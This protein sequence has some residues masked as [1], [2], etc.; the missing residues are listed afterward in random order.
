MSVSVIESDWF[1]AV[2]EAD[3]ERKPRHAAS[4]TAKR[5]GAVG[6]HRAVPQRRRDRATERS[7]QSA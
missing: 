6:Q 1:H 2:A 7:P 5:S 4:G 3:E